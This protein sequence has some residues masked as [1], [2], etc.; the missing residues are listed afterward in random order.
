ML[1]PRSAPILKPHTTQN[2]TGSIFL[3]GNLKRR[4]LISNRQNYLFGFR[5]KYP[6]IEG[7]L[8]QTI[9]RHEEVKERVKD[10]PLQASKHPGRGC[11]RP[12]LGAGPR[13]G[14]P[15]T[16]PLWAP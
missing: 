12:H 1:P 6:K 5:Q 11:Q 7:R 8:G 2:I 4:G 10:H 3:Y 14:V 15:W 9:H 13:G 16:M